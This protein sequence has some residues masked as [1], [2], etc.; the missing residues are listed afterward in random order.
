[1][2][3]QIKT[4]HVLL[5]L[6]ALTAGFLIGKTNI[7]AL[8]NNSLATE[9]QQESQ[10]TTDT[11]QQAAITQQST[12]TQQTHPSQP[13]TG[14]ENIAIKPKFFEEVKN[15]SADSDPWIGSK[16]AQ[17]TIVEFTDYE[18]IFCKKY[19]EEIFP[20]IKENYIDTGKV[21]Y[22]LRDFPMEQHPQS[23][24]AAKTANC[25]DEQ[26]KYWEMH[27]LLFTNQRSWSYS[28]DTTQ[29]LNSYA[30]TLGLNK[31]DF[32]KCIN[33]PNTA[34]ELEKD[35]RDAEIYGITSTPTIFV[36]GK[37]IVGAQPFET[38]F[39]PA[40]DQELAET[41]PKT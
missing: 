41:E 11:Q 29:I 37:K 19:F 30:T 4:K 8:F 28:K 22:V 33:N 1:M 15:V 32:E 25:A 34:N 14:S 39:K 17:V 36:N 18:C 12:T 3:Y 6:A 10:Q 9:Q 5:L 23:S 31:N 21:K 16:D 7:G 26:N 38:V 20:L 27:E 13:S 40:I 2:T 35:I 24:L